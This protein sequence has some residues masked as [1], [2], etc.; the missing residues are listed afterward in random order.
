MICDAALI[1]L[2]NSVWQWRCERWWWWRECWYHFTHFRA[3]DTSIWGG[4]AWFRFFLRLFFDWPLSKIKMMNYSNRLRTHSLT[5]ISIEIFLCGCVF[6]NFP[7]PKMKT[8]MKKTNNSNQLS[9]PM[10]VVVASHNKGCVGQFHTPHNSLFSFSYNK[11]KFTINWACVRVCMCHIFLFSS[12][13]LSIV[14]VF[15]IISTRFSWA[16]ECQAR[17]FS[18]HTVRCGRFSFVN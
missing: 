17:Y 11:K 5:Q 16:I 10:Y 13:Y 14:T 18:T 8:S 7:Q 3:T 12:S 4:F 9:I 2:V 15:F 6:G 1:F